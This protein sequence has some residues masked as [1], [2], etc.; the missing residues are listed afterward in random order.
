MKKSL[1]ICFM[2]FGLCLTA[3]ETEN[4]YGPI[5][6]D[7][8]DQ[9]E[10]PFVVS[11]GLFQIE[12]GFLYT[13]YSP[14]GVTVKET[15]YNTTLLRYGLLDNLELRLGLDVSKVEIDPGTR[16]GS[17]VSGTKPF[18]AGFKIGV[19]EE[20]GLLPQIGFLGGVFLPFAAS[21]EFRPAGVG[22]DFRFAFS[23]TLSDRFD[24]SYNFGFSWNG[25]SPFVSYV[26]SA[27]LGYGFTDKLS[28]FVELYGDLPENA[29]GN[30]LAD[31]GFTYL[32][33]DRLQIDLAGGTGLT[34]EQDFYIGA[35]IS[36]RLPN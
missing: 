27:V 17:E 6:T 11:K 8:P 29:P 2:L 7:R 10:S 13:E 19:A 16:T 9:T 12:T 15:V 26:Y 14:G 24:F 34:T 35:G 28:G 32:L 1:P 23:H 21:E 18:Y 4:P 22:G 30:L 25:D 5:N 31:A 20:K 33:S 36:F 3:Q